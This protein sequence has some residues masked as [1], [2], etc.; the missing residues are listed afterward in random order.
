MCLSPLTDEPAPNRLSALENEETTQ[1][2]FC[3]SLPAAYLFAVLFGLTLCAHVGQAI[4]HRKGYSWVII[5]SALIQFLAYIFRIVSINTP[6]N[7]TSYILW[8]VFI[9]VWVV[10]SVAVPGGKLMTLGC[11]NMDQCVYLHGGGPHDLQ[12]YR[13]RQD[14]ES[15]GLAIRAVFCA[16]GDCVG[17]PLSGYD[18]SILA[19]YRIERC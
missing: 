15:Q 13:I 9:L 2:S 8:F 3:P 11:P 17:S 5:T 16:V 10:L 7:E 4:Y 19:D 1:W 18:R 6:D 12:F 14:H